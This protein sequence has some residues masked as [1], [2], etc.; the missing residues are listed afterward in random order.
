MATHAKLCNFMRV[1]VSR[2]TRLADPD[3]EDSSISNK[4]DVKE[5]WEKYCTFVEEVPTFHLTY[6]EFRSKV[7]VAD[8]YMLKNTHFKN[9]KNGERKLFC[10]TFSKSSF[11]KLTNVEV[12]QHT[13][14]ECQPCE[15]IVDVFYTKPQYNIT[16]EGEKTNY[17]VDMVKDIRKNLEAQEFQNHYNDITPEEAFG[18][19]L[20]LVLK[21]SNAEKR[22]KEE[23]IKRNT[24]RDIEK[25]SSAD[26]KDVE[27]VL[28]TNISFTQYDKERKQNCLEKSQQTKKRNPV[29]N[30]NHYT[31]DKEAF[32]EELHTLHDGATVNWSSLARKYKLFQNDRNGKI[33]DNGGQ[34][35]M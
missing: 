12:L 23:E 28:S 2:A 13:K 3:N 4:I 30:L 5:R 7:K 14:A 34:I 29:G 25:K 16:F 8:S 10:Q 1:L 6:D 9:N 22:S 21:Q 35:L 32:L 33:P 11:D 20:K 15:A 17:G 27:N 31:F 19:S 26:N 18:K 24:A